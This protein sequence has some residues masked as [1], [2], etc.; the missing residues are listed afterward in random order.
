MQQPDDIEAEWEQFV[1]K[2]EDISPPPR[3]PRRRKTEPFV[4]LTLKLAAAAAKAAGGQRL[5]VL[6]WILYRGWKEKSDTVLVSNDALSEY[7][8]SR[9]TKYRA[10]K[11]FEAA[12][13]IR[14]DRPESR[15]PTV[16]ILIGEL[17]R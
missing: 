3:K 13:L 12:G 5:F 2:G 17:D 14:V 9:M 10:L 15:N 1:L 7:G 8:I 16:T 11:N 6:L 4:Q